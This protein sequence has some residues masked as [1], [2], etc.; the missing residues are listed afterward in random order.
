[1]ATVLTW[2]VTTGAYVTKGMEARTVRVRSI[3]STVCGHPY[4][5]F[6]VQ[7]HLSESEIASKGYIV[8]R[9]VCYSEWRQI[10]KRI[11]AFIFTFASK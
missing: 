9:V 1:M 11:F 10:S 4:F 2:F 6:R 8:F 3:D 5:P 7:L